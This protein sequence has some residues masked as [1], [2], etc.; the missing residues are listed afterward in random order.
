[1][2]RAGRGMKK[3]LFFILAG[4]LLSCTSGQQ[5]EPLVNLLTDAPERLTRVVMLDGSCGQMRESSE[6]AHVTAAL[7]LLQSLTVTRQAD[8][9][10]RT[11]YLYWLDL[12]AGEEKLA[13]L[14]FTDRTVQVD[15]VYY[16][17]E[18]VVLDGLDDLFVAL[19]ET[20]A[21]LPPPVP[22]DLADLETFLDN[23]FATHL[24]SH[25][26]PG[27]ALAVVADGRLVLAKG[28]GYADL[29]ANRPVDPAL[30]VFDVGSVSKLFTY[31]AVM[32]LVEQGRLDL[33]ADVNDYLTHFQVPDTFARPVTT[34]HL[35]TH[36][37]GFDEWDIGAA[38]RDLTEVLPVCDYL[39]QRLPPRVRPPGE[40][41]VYSN[42][43][44]ALAGC[45]VEEI[46]GQPFAGYVADNILTPLEMDYSSFG[47]PP[48]LLAN[49][50]TG[51]AQHPAGPRPFATYYRHYGPAG[52]LKA[53]AVDMSHFMIAHLQNG[54]YADAQILQP[55]TVQL[56][57]AQQYSHH[58]RLPGFTYG[59]FEEQFNGR[60]A[61]LHGGDTNP[62]FSS[63]L[64]LLPEENVG[65]FIAH[66]TVEWHFRQRLI[67]AFMDHYYP[68]VSPAAPPLP[69]PDAGERA[70]R[71]AGHYAMSLMQR[72]S[73][74]EKMLGLVS[75]SRLV[76]EADGTLTLHGGGGISL[77]PDGPAEPSRWVEVEPAYFRQV[78]GE[79]VMVFHADENGRIQQMVY[80]EMASVVFTRLAWHQSA[81]FHLGLLAVTAL[82]FLAAV[83][84]WPIGRLR[85]FGSEADR[86]IITLAGSI[87]LLNLF[88]LAGLVWVMQVYALDLIFGPTPVIYLILVL[89][90]VTAVLT[91]I[92]TM[93][94]ILTWRQRE[95]AVARLYSVLLILAA[96]AFIWF[97]NYWNFVLVI[98]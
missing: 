48:A 10:A 66:N 46:S 29:A 7:A 67:V 49:M 25:R 15:D 3:W 96:I 79:G 54:R 82:V 47:W 90:L 75:Q 55:E 35:L 31:T 78:N 98:S 14:T 27:A 8:Q 83:I 20:T 71:Y 70:A 91:L 77:Y 85:R 65:L 74:L 5:P 72:Q 12:Y 30:T 26:I 93:H 23:F 44:T 60:R 68:A 76:A 6:P 86:K 84:V 97:L 40:L 94:T 43:G 69:L 53:T 63:L 62:T 9:S 52:E 28:Y 81:P 24:D 4:L 45:L 34:A 59:F 87:G 19:G 2:N 33:H 17:L 37:G 58:P 57:H 89:P 88:F 22:T 61:L 18:Q 38:V 95:T 42:H 56:M 11:G 64:V 21:N 36:T 50:A 92:L 13:R 32:Q 80:S 41:M 73:N 39:A 16:D 51:Y 1:M